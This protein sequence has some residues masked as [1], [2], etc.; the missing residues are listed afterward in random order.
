MAGSSKSVWGGSIFAVL[1]L[2]FISSGINGT[3]SAESKP[4]D[5]P[6]IDSRNH[7]IGRDVRCV[8]WD[9]G[10][11]TEYPHRAKPISIRKSAASRPSR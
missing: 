1:I 7:N 11:V 9:S 4:V 6:L 2:L 3:F 8:I 5:R 10:Q